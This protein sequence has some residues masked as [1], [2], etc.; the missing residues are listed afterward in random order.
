MRKVTEVAIGILLDKAGRFL[1]ASRPEGKPYAGWWEFPGG[2]LEAGETVLQALAREYAEEL[3]VAVHEATPWFVF[4]REYP[5][6]H[7]RLHCC[8]ITGWEGEPQSQ[9][10]QVFRWFDDLE[11][12]QQE[13]ILPMCDLV[14]RRLRLPERAARVRNVEVPETAERFVRSGAR[15]LLADEASEDKLR[16]ARALGVE[17]I[18]C[19]E[20]MRT[21]EETEN[22]ALQEELIGILA[23]EADV[24]GILTAAR[25]CVP[26][27]VPAGNDPGQDK[28]MLRLGAQGVYVDIG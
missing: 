21:T 27:Y 20:A 2:K 15:V 24:R 7:V 12:A 22:P 3:A 25:Q 19:R 5:H 8:R 9:E 16:L 17:L 4:E 18:V 23:R 10:G 28:E 11:Q 1:M 13:Q 26:L 6:A 14:I